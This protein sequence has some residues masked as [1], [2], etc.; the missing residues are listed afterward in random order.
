MSQFEKTLFTSKDKIEPKREMHGDFEYDK[1]LVLPRAGNQCTIA[2]M[3]VAPGKSAYPYHC[4]VGITEVFYI[5]SGDG[6]VITPDGER[7]VKSGDV[8]AFP[9]GDAGAHRIVNT[10]ESETLCYLDCKCCIIGNISYQKADFSKYNTEDVWRL[11]VVGKKRS[12]WRH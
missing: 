7:H 5:I 9:P 10:S 3:D 2:F 8:I 12:A 11:S 4:H 6:L 1:Y